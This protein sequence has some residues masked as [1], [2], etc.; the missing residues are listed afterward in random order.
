MTSELDKIHLLL[1]HWQ[2]PW[3]KGDP[4][5]LTHNFDGTLKEVK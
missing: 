3:P 5:Y 2:M 1:T 4:R